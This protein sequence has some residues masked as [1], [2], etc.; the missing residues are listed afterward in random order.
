MS[1]K[2]TEIYFFLVKLIQFL[3]HVHYKL[4]TILH[5]GV[6]ECHAPIHPATNRFHHQLFIQGDGQGHWSHGGPKSECIGEGCGAFAE[7]VL[8]SVSPMPP[9][10]LLS[11]PTVEISSLDSPFEHSECFCPEML[12][13]LWP[14]ASG[15]RPDRHSAP[16]P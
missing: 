6:E 14:Q 12:P 16:I 1:S 7:L 10:S 8:F 4:G 2:L 11:L 3:I 9:F 15:E 5:Y 13:F